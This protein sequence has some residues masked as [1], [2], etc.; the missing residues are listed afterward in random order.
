MSG[1]ATVLISAVGAD[2]IAGVQV[3]DDANQYQAPTG[4]RGRHGRSSPFPAPG[5]PGGRL[6]MLMGFDPDR[7]GL[8]QMTG[9]GALAGAR[10]E[11][12][13]DAEFLLDVHGGNGGAGGIGEIG[14]NGGHGFDGEDATKRSRGGVS[15]P[16]HN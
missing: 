13:A 3:W 12:G 8:V 15:E 10:W 14:Q 5:G 11:V 7:P 1:K 4:A 6:D 9:E 2:G 16:P